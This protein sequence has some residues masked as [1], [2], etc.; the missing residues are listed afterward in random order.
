MNLLPPPGPERTR[1]L[2]S[3]GVLTIVLAGFLWYR[4]WPATA[5][6]AAATSKVEG[7]G[8]G[9]ADKDKLPLPDAVELAKLEP[10]PDASQ[11]GRNPFRYGQK[12][13]PPAPPLPPPQPYVAPTPT[14]PPGP[15]G[16]PAIQLKLFGIELVRPTNQRLAHL[17]DP[18]SGATFLVAEGA[19]IDGKYKLVKMNADSVVLSYLNGQGMKTVYLER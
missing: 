15:V 18:E 2:V 8:S 1:Q 4:Y 14:P 13:P 5:T 11:L 17:L 16:P 10:A 19:Q 9:S 12:P 7:K 3:L 6:T